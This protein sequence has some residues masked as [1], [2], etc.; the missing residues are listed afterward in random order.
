[1]TPLSLPV[2]HHRVFAN[3]LPL[4]TLG[5]LTMRE[6]GSGRVWA[7]YDRRYTVCA[8]YGYCRKNWG[9]YG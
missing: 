9:I 5:V 6:R 4:M 2:S 1:M 8:K 7:V 3:L